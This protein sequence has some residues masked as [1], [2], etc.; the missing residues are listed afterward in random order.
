MKHT[1][2]WSRLINSLF[3]LYS[4]AYTLGTLFVLVWYVL[5]VRHAAS[6]GDRA[7]QFLLLLGVG[8]GV[9]F[10]SIALH[11]LGWRV[12][13]RGVRYRAASS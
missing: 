10:V 6:A 9:W 13:P 5:D 4:V 1:A 2:V 3:A 8:C 7:M 11:N 12:H